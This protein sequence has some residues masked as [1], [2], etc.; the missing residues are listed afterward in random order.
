LNVSTGVI[1]A[2]SEG[3]VVRV[4]KNDRANPLVEF[5]NGT[6][7]FR[8]SVKPGKL[9]KLTPPPPAPNVNPDWSEAEREAIARLAKE[10]DMS[11]QGVLRQALRSYQ[12]THYA[13]QTHSLYP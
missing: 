10:K 4:E 13:N 8:Y 2:G 12:A 6:P 7:G 11:P 5:D 1:Q 3:T 9:R